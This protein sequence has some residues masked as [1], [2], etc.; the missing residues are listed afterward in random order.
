VWGAEHHST[1]DTAVHAMLGK[2]RLLEDLRRG[3]QALLILQILAE[4]GPLHGYWLRNH[5][6]QALGATPPESTLYTLLKRL[7]KEG[8]ITGYWAQG[9][10]GRLRRYYQLTPQGR[11]ALNSALQEAK[12]ILAPHICR[13]TRER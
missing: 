5:L 10:Q 11:E 3:L 4:K 12:R 7:E 8:L 6:A 9:P 13:E 2:R 1:Q